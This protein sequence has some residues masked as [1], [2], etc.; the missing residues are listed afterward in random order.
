MSATLEG[1]IVALIILVAAIGLYFL[2]R[3]RKTPGDCA[4]CGDCPLAE[5]CRKREKSTE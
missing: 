4:D 5:R 1:A 3:R 2:L